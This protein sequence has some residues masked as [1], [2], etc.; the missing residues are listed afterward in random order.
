MLSFSPLS[1]P[2]T[3]TSKP[4]LAPSGLSAISSGAWNATARGSNRKK[5]KS[6]TG[7]A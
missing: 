1:L 2:T 4:T 6:C 3:R 5:A 7:S